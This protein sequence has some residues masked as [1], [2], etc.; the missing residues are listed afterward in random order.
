MA[1][2]IHDNRHNQDADRGRVLL[3]GDDGRMERTLRRRLGQVQ[4]ICEDNAL[5]G[6]VRLS[7]I[8]TATVLVHAG[9]LEQQTAE[10]VKALR[11]ISPISTILVYGEPFSEVYAREAL[12]AG[13]DDY[14]IQPIPFSELREYLLPA[15]SQ[16][17]ASIRGS[18]RPATWIERLHESNGGLAAQLL[19][20]Y[21]EL[22][23]LIP[24]GKEVL[25][26]QAQK[27]LAQIL[28]VEWVDILLAERNGTIADSGGNAARPGTTNVITM[29]GPLGTIGQLVLGPAL[30]PALHHQAP[31]QPIG[32]LLATLFH[33][34]ERDESLKHLATV[35]ELTQAYNRRYM[36]YFL[37]QIIGQNEGHD[38][39][40]TLL[41]FDID[42]FKYYNDTYGHIA[43]D[44]ILCEATR[45]IRRCCRAHDIVARIGGD[46]FAVLFWDTGEPREP[47]TRDEPEPVTEEFDFVEPQPS[48]KHH[49]QIAM[50]LSN[51]FRRAMKTNEFP[52]LG[53]DARGKLTISGGLACYPYDGKSLEELF[54][55]ADEALL[56]AKRYGKNRIYLVGQPNSEE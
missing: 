2:D 47:Y 7:E 50:F 10:A 48:H 52:S 1:Q 30:S 6:I 37:R 44:E 34:A 19:T 18:T 11:R 43:G 46:E 12:R 21:Q 38:P 8:P 28:Y 42:E 56:S 15:H 35:D 29:N 32:D 33:L 13:A 45:L 55:K 41:L 20:Q 49:P 23:Q 9:R 22:A 27:Q 24:K 53:P 26:E 5:D 4:L 40:V 54:A 14:I 31:A 16:P 36:E 39:E 3:L 25:L 17:T 51:R